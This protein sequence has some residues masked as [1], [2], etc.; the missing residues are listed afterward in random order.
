[1]MA[2][3]YYFRVFELEPLEIY[4][5]EANTRREAEF[6]ISNITY[7]LDQK[8]KWEYL[9]E[10]SGEEEVVLSDKDKE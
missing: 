7:G 1:M 6:K 8:L 4:T 10:K 9:Y 5:I 2:N 3:T